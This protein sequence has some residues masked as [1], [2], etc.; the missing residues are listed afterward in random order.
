MIMRH[1]LLAAAMGGTA[2]TASV[3]GWAAEPQSSIAPENAKGT[4][5]Y[6]PPK[7]GAPRGRVGG[8]ARGPSSDMPR[9][10]VLAPD[11]PGLTTE[12]QPV[13]YWYL[14]RPTQ[15]S[16]E[17]TLMTDDQIAPV[18]EVKLADAGQPGVHKL[19]LADHG[20]TLEL[21]A[22]YRW[23]VSVVQD[24]SRRSRDVIAGGVIQ[25]VNIP[26]GLPEKLAAAKSEDKAKLLASEGIWYDAIAALSS[27]I[28]GAPSNETLR[29][30]R[31]G[32]LDQVG[33]TDVATFDRK[34]SG[35]K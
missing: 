5:V 19:S 3:S 15:N 14:N 17:F 1:L 20:V 22:T 16:V 26:N 31:A 29:E 8:G 21:N 24:P 9:L 34:G 11:H 12:A 10:T 23:Y 35:N 13:L 6:V 25:R 27:S 2:A 4:P 33:L 28:D 7:V 32:L 18:L 30:Q